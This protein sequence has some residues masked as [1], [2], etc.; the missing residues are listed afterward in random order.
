M[1]AQLDRECIAV[2]DGVTA[3]LYRHADFVA[4]FQTVF[5]ERVAT[6]TT[7]APTLRVMLRAVAG[8]KDPHMHAIVLQQSLKLLMNNTSP[9]AQAEVLANDLCVVATFPLRT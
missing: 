1:L 5:L 3:V 6:L 8:L 4:A 7:S 2:V 9:V